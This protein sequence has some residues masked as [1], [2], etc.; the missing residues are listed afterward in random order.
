[1]ERYTLTYEGRARFRRMETRAKADTSTSTEDFRILQYLYGHG[2]ASI[3]EIESNLELSWSE[4]I[5]EVADLVNRGYIEGFT[6]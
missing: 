5:N 1:M 3:K 6:E 4:T 2:P